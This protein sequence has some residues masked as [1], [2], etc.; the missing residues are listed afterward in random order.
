M[1]KYLLAAGA[2]VM[3]TQ[4]APAAP[5]PA[6]T[7]ADSTAVLTELADIRLKGI[8]PKLLAEAHGVAVI[9]RVIKAGFV[10][11]GRGGHGVVLARDE[12]GNWGDPVFVNLGGGSVGFQVGVESTDVVLVFRSKRSLERLLE[13]KGKVTLGADAA[14]A[15][16]PVGRQAMAGTDAKLEAEILSYSRSRGLFA[17]VSLDG[18]VIRPDPGTNALFRRDD[19]ADRAWADALRAKLTALSADAPAGVLEAPV[20]PAAV[21]ATGPTAPTTMPA[22]P[23][24]TRRFRILRRP[25]E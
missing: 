8:P 2:A 15:A 25:G 4:T 1:T 17:G 13:G 19:P 11:A 18:T 10:A 21:P 6:K 23:T 14:V 24:G 7:L 5:P 16:G 9:P 3:V 20:V 22:P 12:A